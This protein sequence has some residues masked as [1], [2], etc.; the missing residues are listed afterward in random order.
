MDVVRSSPPLGS[1]GYLTSAQTVWQKG[2]R[3]HHRQTE[4]DA[5]WTSFEALHRLAAVAT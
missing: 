2:P 4:D 1:G 3:S 5:G